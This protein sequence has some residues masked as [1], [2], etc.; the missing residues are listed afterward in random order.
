MKKR[1]L[2]LLLTQWLWQ[3]AVLAASGTNVSQYTARV[4][5]NAQQLADNNALADAIAKLNSAEVSRPDDVAALSKLLGIYYWQAEQFTRSIASLEK[6]L[7]FE[8]FTFEEEWVT[9][10]MLTQLYLTQG[11]YK[12][13]IPQ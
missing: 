13:A 3:P 7:S 6:A 1:I 4:M 5:Q 11:D 8:L 12:K 10:R 2:T 9:R